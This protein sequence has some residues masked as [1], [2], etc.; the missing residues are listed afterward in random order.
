MVIA[1]NGKGINYQAY[2]LFNLELVVFLVLQRIKWKL[3]VRLE[4]N[5]NIYRMENT[6]KK[7][8][9]VNSLEN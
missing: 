4:K 3:C 5:K 1:N 6:C 9:F 8:T 7:T 2:Y